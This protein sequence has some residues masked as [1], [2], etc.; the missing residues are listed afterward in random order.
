[1]AQPG[2]QV[3]VNSGAIVVFGGGT[4]SPPDPFVAPIVTSAGDMPAL[5]RAQGFPEVKGLTV[6]Y[7]GPLLRDFGVMADEKTQ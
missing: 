2:L 5:D 3:L 4:G 7:V 6:V 1:M